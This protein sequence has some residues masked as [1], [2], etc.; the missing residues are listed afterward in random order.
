MER[1]SCKNSFNN[2]LTKVNSQVSIWDL[3]SGAMYRVAQTCKYVSWSMG[4][5]IDE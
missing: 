3:D 2:L 4:A 5:G 1:A